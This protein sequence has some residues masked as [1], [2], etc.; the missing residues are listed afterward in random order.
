MTNSLN[1]D[2]EKKENNMLIA[3]TETNAWEMEK[4]TYVFDT[5]NLGA[6]VINNLIVFARMA[7]E[8]FDKQLA[9]VPKNQPFA[10]SRYW[11]RFYD[12]LD[13]GND[14]YTR[15][16]NQKSTL[17]LNASD[18]QDYKTGGIFLDRKLSIKRLISA[19]ISIR[20]RQENKIYKNF[21]SL[22]IKSPL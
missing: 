2:G 15:L 17:I 5:N 10:M 1:R 3:I 11:V 18:Y 7:N 6:S 12:R 20:D 21:E 16:I 19:C 8:E 9:L 14:G 4:W 22:L 13:K